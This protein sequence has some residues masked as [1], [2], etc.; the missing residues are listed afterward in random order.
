MLPAVDDQG[1]THFD[2]A[3]QIWFEDDAA[4]QAAV[5][6]PLF[7]ESVKPDE[8]NFIDTNAAMTLSI[9]EE[10]RIIWPQAA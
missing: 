3:A 1:P 4:L 2:G 9:E 5:R 8:A 7:R 10:H 6:S